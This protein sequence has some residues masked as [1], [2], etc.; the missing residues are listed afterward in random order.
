MESIVFPKNPEPDGRRGARSGRKSEVAPTKY[1][2]NEITDGNTALARRQPVPAKRACSGKCSERDVFRRKYYP[3]ITQ[4]QFND[5][6][7]QLANRI[8]TVEQVSRII[9][10]TDQERDALS[11]GVRLPFAVTPYYASLMSAG[12]AGDPI[13]R[14][15]IPSI[16]EFSRSFGE[17]EDPLDEEGCSPVP[18]IVHRYPDRVLFM[19]TGMCSTYCRYCTRSRLVTDGHTPVGEKAWNAAID[20]IASHDEVRDVLISGGDPLTLSDEKLEWLLARLRRIEHVE[21]IRIGT[22]VPVV[23]PQRI[24]SKL[25]SILRRYHPLLMSI[26][27]THP[28]EITPECAAACTRLADAGIPLGSQTVLLKGINDD[29]SVIRELVLGML[30]IRVRP[31]YLYQCDPIIGSAHFRTPVHKGLE[32]I[33]GL[34][35]HVSGYAVPTYVIDAPG[36]GGKIPVMPDYVVGHED[37][38]LKLR[39][40]EG[41]IFSYPV[42]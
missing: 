29:V 37:G 14:T 2:T 42:R 32:I 31:Y 21:I 8:I 41:K 26:H 12:N 17:E 19:A 3:G 7:W 4:A 27:F 39:N 13:R 6:R 36:G 1:A 22:K 10:L 35:G 15:V 38:Y 28:R 18:G 25:V 20:Y 23:L 33:R 16:G 40:Y 5:W 34:R 30:K 11:R 24:T 9:D